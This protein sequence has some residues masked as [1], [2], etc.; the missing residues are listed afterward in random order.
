M[1][2]APSN[3]NPDSS[4]ATRTKLPAASLAAHAL[5]H[6]FQIAD[7]GLLDTVPVTARYGR[8]SFLQVAFIGAL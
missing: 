3:L 1:S 5:T 8:Q 6:R 2:I 4:P 7:R